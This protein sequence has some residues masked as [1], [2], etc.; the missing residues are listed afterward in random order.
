MR[1]VSWLVFTKGEE[2]VVFD[3]GMALN[4]FLNAGIAD[5]RAVS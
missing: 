3:G 2:S 1:S 5:M 4:S